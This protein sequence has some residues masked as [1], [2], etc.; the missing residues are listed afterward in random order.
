[1]HYAELFGEWTLNR[2]YS[3]AIQ[4]KK[5]LSVSFGI[6]L[7]VD[8]IHILNGILY[9]TNL[10]EG[11]LDRVPITVN[12]STRGPAQ[13]FANMTD[14]DDF[15]LAEGGI[16]CVAGANILY[17]VNQNGSKNILVALRSK[18][19]RPLSLEEPGWTVACCMLAQME[20]YWH[21]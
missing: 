11:I 10:G 8:S 16:A 12:G 5:L 14:S 19:L 2:G 4:D 13:L 9:Y 15:T 17:R 3:V 6:P 7:G 18:G 20:V 21:L 1:M